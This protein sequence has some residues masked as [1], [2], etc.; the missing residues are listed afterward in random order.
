V[1]KI[2]ARDVKAA[3]RM[4][5]RAAPEAVIVPE[6]RS[7]LRGVREAFSQLRLLPWLGSRV[8]TRMFARAKLG[9]AWL[10]IRPLMDTFG[11]ALIYGGILSAPTSNGVPYFIFLTVGMMGWMLFQRSLTFS[12]RSLRFYRRMIK[13]MDFPLVLVP[14]AAGALGAVEFGFYTLILAGALTYYWFANGV[15]Y[16]N[17]GPEFLLGVLGVLG[18]LMFAWALGFWLS[19]LNAKAEDVRMSLRYVLGFWLYLTPIIYPLSAIP[20]KYQTIAALNPMAPWIEMV[21][22]GFLGAGEIRLMPL[23][24]SI[25]VMVVVGASGLWFFNREARRSANMD[26]AF[27]DD[28]EDE[29]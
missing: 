13:E 25:G 26:D 29:L 4:A 11:K 5:L 14:V 6:K 18:C 10:V 20:P 19:V 9:R 16:L 8:V 23:A 15:M 1:A 2:V 3:R 22:T 7:V 24:S 28:D 17:V 12:V 27:M 21:K